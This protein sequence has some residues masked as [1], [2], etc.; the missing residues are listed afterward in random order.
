MKITIVIEDMPSGKTKVT[1]AYPPPHNSTT[2]QPQR[3][4]N[5]ERVVKRIEQ[6]IRD[7]KLF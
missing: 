7:E 1:Y 4:T 3:L 5:A 2:S 6:L